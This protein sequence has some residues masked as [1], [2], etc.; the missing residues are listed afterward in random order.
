MGFLIRTAFWLSLVLLFLPLGGGSDEAGEFQTVGAL[1]TLLAARDA[2]ADMA[3]MCERNPHVC[4]TAKAAASTVLI[5]ARAGINAASEMMADDTPV[6][7]SEA[8]VIAKEEIRRPQV[9]V[10]GSISPTEE[11]ERAVV[12]PYTPPVPQADIAASR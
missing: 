4:E 2:A 9:T 1:D 12:R 3:G 7:A 8:P 11:G 10:T 5:R 6:Q